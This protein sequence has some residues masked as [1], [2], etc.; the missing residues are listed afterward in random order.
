MKQSHLLFFVTTRDCLNIA[1]R[2]AYPVQ[3]SRQAS[4]V[5]CWKFKMIVAFRALHFSLLARSVTGVML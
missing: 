2:E 5:R 3:N 4:I 1:A